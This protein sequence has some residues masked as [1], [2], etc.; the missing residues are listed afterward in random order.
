MDS[1]LL[2]PIIAAHNAASNVGGG[3]GIPFVILVSS[4]VFLRPSCNGLAS[5]AVWAS[6]IRALVIRLRSP[7]IIPA[8]GSIYFSTSLI[9]IF[10]FYGPILWTL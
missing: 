3:E 8:G 2:I 1:A 4:Y 7:F 9:P 5:L 6:N 10:V